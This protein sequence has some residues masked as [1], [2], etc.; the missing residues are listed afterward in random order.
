MN[1]ISIE[2]FVGLILFFICCIHIFLIVLTNSSY[3]VNNFPTIFTSFISFV[4]VPWW[5]DIILFLVKYGFFGVVLA[6]VFIIFIF[7][8][9]I[10][11]LTYNSLV[12]KVL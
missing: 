10:L 8:V 7:K 9:K 6:V 5:T 12:V 4:A 11:G 3:L 1:N 2:K